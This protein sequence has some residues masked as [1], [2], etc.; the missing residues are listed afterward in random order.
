MFIGN[1]SLRFIPFVRGILE[2]SSKLLNPI[3]KPFSGLLSGHA[4]NDAD[5]IPPKIMAIEPGH[6]PERVISLTQSLLQSNPG[7][8]L[9]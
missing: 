2:Q 1:L 5:L 8:N 7:L 4:K 9:F 6:G 3:F